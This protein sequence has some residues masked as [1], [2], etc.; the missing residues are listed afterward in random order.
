M[1]T[2]FQ[3]INNSETLIKKTLKSGALD[4]TNS[5]YDRLNISEKVAKIYINYFN[6]LIPDIKSKAFFKPIEQVRK[7]FFK[8]Y[9][10]D[11]SN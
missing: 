8:K 6:D 7:D 1:Y 2:Y 5:F 3:S 4:G 11:T 10:L 9:L